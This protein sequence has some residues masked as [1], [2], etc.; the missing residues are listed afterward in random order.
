MYYSEFWRVEQRIWNAGSDG[1]AIA[2][3]NK[4]ILFIALAHV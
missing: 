1:C 2:G 3:K 4:L